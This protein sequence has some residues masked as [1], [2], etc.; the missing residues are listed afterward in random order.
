MTREIHLTTEQELILLLALQ[1]EYDRVEKDINVELLYPTETRRQDI[2]EI[3]AQ[4]AASQYF[5]DFNLE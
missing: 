5:E 1:H 2:R 3:A 4:F